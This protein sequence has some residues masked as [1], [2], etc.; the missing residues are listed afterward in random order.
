MPREARS[1][2]KIKNYSYEF[3][4]DNYVDVHKE[5][6]LSKKKNVDHY[7]IIN[8]LITNAWVLLKKIVDHPYLIQHPIDS[9]EEYY[10]DLLSGSGKMLVLDTMLSKLKRLNHKILLFSTFTTML[11]I[12]EDLLNYKGY[13]YRRLDGSVSLNDRD[14][15]MKEFNE[16]SDIFVFLL[17]TRAGGVGLNLTGADTVIFYDRDWVRRN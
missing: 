9:D 1:C 15:A 3:N 13:K 6:E 8:S 14:V 10:K 17:S 7:S 5:A 4:V 2:R 16:D 11:D 12:I